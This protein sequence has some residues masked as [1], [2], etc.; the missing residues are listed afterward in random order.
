MNGRQP[1]SPSLD[2]NPKF[3]YIKG[4]VKMMSDLANAMKQNAT[5]EQKRTEARYYLFGNK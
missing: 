3:G 2:R 5:P 4:K 1:N